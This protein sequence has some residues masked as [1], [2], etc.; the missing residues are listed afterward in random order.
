MKEIKLKYAKN[1]DS[2]GRVHD[3][4]LRFQ[5]D[6]NLLFEVMFIDIRSAKIHMQHL[7][8]KRTKQGRIFN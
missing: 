8:K 1:V 5:I 7:K 3:D 4:K 2:V 6:D